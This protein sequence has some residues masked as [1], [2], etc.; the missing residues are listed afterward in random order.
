MPADP[1]GIAGFH[2]VVMT[3]DGRVI[4]LITNEF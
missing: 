3:P 2:T 4:A 1:A